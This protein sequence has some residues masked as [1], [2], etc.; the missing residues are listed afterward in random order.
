MQDTPIPQHHHTAQEPPD[1]PMGRDGGRPNWEEIYAGRPRWDIGRPQPA[2]LA[3]AQSGAIAGRVL[4][5]GCGTGEHVLMCAAAGLEATGVDIAA[6]VISAA[7]YKAHERGLPARFLRHD[8]R[9]LADLG[10]SFDTVLD[11]G[12]LVHVLDDE[13][14]RTAYLQGLQAVVP[15]GGRYFVL[16]FRGPQANSRA[17]HLVRED[18]TACFTAGWRI[19][20]IEATTLDSRTDENGVPA[21]LIALTRT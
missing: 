18:I 11:S 20:S 16:C 15:S 14:D 10:E 2:F 17:R 3:L 6:A 8:V 4:D 12:L 5:V 19:D 7:E 1:L 13:Q 21:W 9:R